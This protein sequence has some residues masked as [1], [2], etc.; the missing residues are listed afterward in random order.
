M[1]FADGKNRVLIGGITG[2]IGSALA[3]L[4]A[5][6]GCVV[7][8]FARS[9]KG[10]EALVETISQLDF[11]EADAGDSAAVEKAVSAFAEK[12]GGLDAYVHAVGNVFLKPLHLMSDEEWDRVVHLNLDSAFYAA[13]AAVKVMRRQKG[14]CLLFFSSVAAQAGLSNHEAIAASKGGVVGL[15]RSIAATYAGNGIRANAI[16]PGLVETPATAPLTSSEQALRISEKM[17]P[18]GRI[19]TSAEVASLAAW[20]LS[21]EAS[22]M[23]GQ[24][25]SLDGGMSSIVPKPRV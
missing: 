15:V 11:H 13:R 16:A 2:G 12:H 18:L 25:L 5:A 6:E 17:H 3:T 7:G 19:G 22:W 9:S 21:N 24:V 8:G 10:A 20:L 14:G 1:R 23:T 4:L